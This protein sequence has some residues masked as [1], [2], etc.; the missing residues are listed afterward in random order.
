[1]RR[2]KIYC[3]MYHG[4]KRFKMEWYVLLW[5]RSIGFPAK[6]QGDCYA[7]LYRAI[8]YCVDKEGGN[9]KLILPIRILGE[10]TMFHQ[11]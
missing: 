11:I 5:R 8:A 9:I 1:M 4:N 2:S 6:F 10:K 3:K 7:H